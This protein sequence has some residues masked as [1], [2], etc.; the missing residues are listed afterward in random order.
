MDEEE[1]K[2]WREYRKVITKTETV[3]I[4]SLV[5]VRVGERRNWDIYTCK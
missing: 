5:T 2:S 1:R 4:D 3:I